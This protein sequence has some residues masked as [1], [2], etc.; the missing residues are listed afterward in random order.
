MKK[1]RHSEKRSGEKSI[2]PDEFFPKSGCLASLC[3]TIN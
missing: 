3:V 2:F 1:A